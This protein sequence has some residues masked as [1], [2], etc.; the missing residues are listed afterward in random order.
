MEVEKCGD[1]PGSM[2]KVFVLLRVT[3]LK[4]LIQ[5][6]TLMQLT[7]AKGWLC[8][9]GAALCY[10][11]IPYFTV[12]LKAVGLENPSIL[13]YRFAIA[14]VVVG[15][16]MRLKGVSFR[17]TRGEMVTLTYLAFISDGSALFLIESYSYMSTGVA[18]TLH[19]LYP[20][21]TT[22]IMISFY[23]EARRWTTF[24]AVGMA[25]SGVAVLS[26]HGGESLSLRGV[27]I[28]VVSAVCYA[29][30]IIRVNRSR[31]QYM[32]GIKV[33]F[34]VMAIGSL[35]FLADALRTGAV[36]PLTDGAEWGR[37]GALALV[38]TVATN[39]MLVA[40]VKRIGSTLT[41][42]I[43]ALEPLTAVVVG[44]V[45]LGEPFTASVA[46][47]LVLII[48]AIVLIILTRGRTPQP[49]MSHT[50]SLEKTT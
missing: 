31:A 40:S 9:L 19:F 6:A 28:A 39:L 13:F 16:L 14:A 7:Q 35:I 12:P 20:V 47:G 21:V 48:P 50:A 33:V 36:Q 1:E 44:C 27:I 4:K 49:S 3:N 10:G 24:V 30:Y 38:C 41:S 17:V 8:G 26:W 45:A 15:I 18:T 23:H 37:V 32:P 42:I 34:Y 43:G 25:V 5:D 22:L 46:G 11:F 29:L 2:H